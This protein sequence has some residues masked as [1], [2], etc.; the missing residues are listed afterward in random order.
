MADGLPFGPS[1]AKRE[2]Y[3]FRAPAYK[4]VDMGL[5]YCLFNNEH[6]YLRYEPMRWARSAWFGIDFFNLL[7]INNVNSYYWITD[8]TNTQYAVPN[9]L[10]GRQI[11]FRLM[12]DI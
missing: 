2:L 1:H 3:K 9:Y 10:T 5:S 8:I 6:K 12:L 4:R 7:D 11:S